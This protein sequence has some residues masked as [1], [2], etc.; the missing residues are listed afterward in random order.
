MQKREEQ[1]KVHVLSQDRILDESI[2]LVRVEPSYDDEISLID[3]WIVIAK[4][5]KLILMIVLIALLLGASAAMTKKLQYKYSVTLQIGSLV[6]EGSDGQKFQYI[7]SPQNVLAKLESSYIPTIR[8]LWLN[9]TGE[10]P[11][12]IIARIPKES[13]LIMLE[14]EGEEDEGKQLLA[15]LQEVVDVVKNDHKPSMNVTRGEF[16]SSLNNAERVLAELTDVNSIEVLTEGKKT[17]LVTAKLK[18]D[19]LQNEHLIK[20]AKQQLQSDLESH[21]NKLSSINDQIKL[22]EAELDR[23]AN[24]D[25]LLEKQ[26]V[27]LS[28]TISNQ[29]KNRRETEESVKTG[30]GAMTL[31]LI[32]NQIQGNRDRLAELEERLYIKQHEL[33]RKIDNQIKESLR[34]R[35]YEKMLIADINNQLQKLDIDNE[36]ARQKQISIVSGLEIQ[37]AKIKRD[38]QYAILNQQQKI[39]D[40]KLKLA[41]LKDTQALSEPMRSFKSLPRK[42]GLTLAVSVIAG[43]FIAFAI[44]FV[45]EF[46]SKVKQREQQIQNASQ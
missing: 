13:S 7:E 19:E 24:V 25:T 21:K 39:E 43:L 45:L 2:Q 5:W 22:L 14:V 32:D 41:G 33:R 18:L 8:Q 34:E 17:Q 23:L 20:V 37:L 10:N 15:L 26:I 30:P 29:L 11:P 3:L 46:L 36:H 40:L 42:R 12:D 31:L 6:V 9:K 38:H 16:S 1:N 28:N 4:R 44:V 35:D 27:D